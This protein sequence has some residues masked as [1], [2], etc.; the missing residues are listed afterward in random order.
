MNDDA[1]DHVKNAF[2]RCDPI[3][4]ILE[5]TLRQQ[6]RSN[7][8]ILNDYQGT[9]WLICG[10]KM[11]TARIS[12]EEIVAC[13]NCVATVDLLKRKLAQAGIDTRPAP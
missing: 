5:V 1:P 3:R 7:A 2:P 12:S 13:L 9:G 6:L 8:M 11:Q 4:D 10:P